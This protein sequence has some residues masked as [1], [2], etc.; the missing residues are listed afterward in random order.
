M[1]ASRFTAIPKLKRPN[2]KQPRFYGDTNPGSG[3][4]GAGVPGVMRMLGTETGAGVGAI[5]GA[6]AG[7]TFTSTFTFCTTGFFSTRMTAL[8]VLRG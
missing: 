7:V 4:V 6:G 3:E 5:A 2:P 1:A 8:C